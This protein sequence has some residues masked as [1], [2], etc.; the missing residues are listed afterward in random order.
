M[1]KLILENNL[2]CSHELMH[3]II[4]IVRQKLR[5]FQ[6]IEFV[7]HFISCDKVYFHS[8]LM[9]LL[10]QLLLLHFLDIWFP[11]LEHIVET[12]RLVFM[13]FFH[14]YLEKRHIHFSN[15]ILLI[16]DFLKKVRLN[17]DVLWEFWKNLLSDLV[18]LCMR[19]ILFLPYFFV[20]QLGKLFI[21]LV[22][23]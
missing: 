19:P 4:L 22:L 15:L 8:R 5:M 9:H 13:E 20:G 21:D 7:I 18:L 14:S 23:K 2:P 3:I 10:I 1:L 12:T 16:F 11:C 17:I 6:L